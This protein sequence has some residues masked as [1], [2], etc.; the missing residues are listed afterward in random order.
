MAYRESLTDITGRWS[1]ALLG[2]GTYRLLGV[3]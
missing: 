1:T 3:A 2:R